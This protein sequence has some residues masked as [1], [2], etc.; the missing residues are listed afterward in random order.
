MIINKEPL[1]SVGVALY[2]TLNFELKGT[3]LFGQKTVQPG[4]YTATIEAGLIST[5]FSTGQKK[6]RLN[7]K[8]SHS[9]FVLKEVTIGI[10]FHWEKHENQEFEGAL[11]LQPENGKIRAVN[12]VLLETYLESV[13]S[14]EMSAM[15]DPEL[16][17]THAIVSRSWLLAQIFK[18]DDRKQVRKSGS[19]V[20]TDEQGEVVEV[21]KW[22][23]REDHQTFDVCA[24]DHCQRYQGITKVLSE[25]AQKAVAATRGRVLVFNNEICDARFSKC[26]GGISEDFSKVW[27]PVHVPYLTAVRDLY[28]EQLPIGFDAEAFIRS[29]PDSFCKTTDTEVLKQVLVDFDRSTHDFY[30]WKVKY[31]QAEIGELIKRKSGFDFGKIQNLVPLERGKSGRIIRLQIEGT[32]G[33][34]VVGKEL[35][36]RKWLSESHLYSSA[37][38]VDRE[39]DAG[40]D[41][42]SQF[43]LHG[44]GWGHGVGMCQIGAAVMCRKG[45]RSEEILKHYYPGTQI[46]CYYK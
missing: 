31:T 3:F 45:Y 19:Q 42:P 13:I 27:Q 26:C 30:R 11:I 20:K 25:N 29:S 16:L 6:L 5:S 34:M 36:I 10:G 38:V 35:E 18:S 8:N 28:S 15:N 17:K 44:A 24:D 22:Y 21:C 33:S 14:S 9:T 1:V 39:F 4:L 37:F 40:S 43:I 7:P 46:S 2:S 23:D 12:R 41:S 32:K